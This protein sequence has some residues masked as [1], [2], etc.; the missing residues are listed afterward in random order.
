LNY[1]VT[2]DPALASLVSLDPLT[3][4]SLA[5]SAIQLV[6]F[7]G[8]IISKGKSLYKSVEGVIRENAELEE[9]TARLKESCISL[10]I[11]LPLETAVSAGLTTEDERLRTTCE[12]CALVSEELISCLQSLKVSSGARRRGLESLRKA[13]KTVLS[14]SKCDAL[15]GRLRDLRA[16]LDTHILVILE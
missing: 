7:S 3:A 13:L 15:L 5:A 2:Y 12:A 4:L 14:T 11:A 8:K 1:L 6:D 10:K 16:E 9:S